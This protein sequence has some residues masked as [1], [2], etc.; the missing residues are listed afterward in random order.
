MHQNRWRPGLCPG[1]HWGSLQRSRT[2]YSAKHRGTSAWALRALA[3]NAWGRQVEPT[4]HHHLKK[5]TPPLHCSL[6]V[7]IDPPLSWPA[8]FSVYSCEKSYVRQS[9]LCVWPFCSHDRSNAVCYFLFF[10][11]H[12]C[13]FSILFW[14]PHSVISVSPCYALYS[15]QAAYLEN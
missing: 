7:V 12:Q 14:Y 3:P 2:P 11:L 5:H 8:S 1:P 4:A 15:S 13:L 9:E 6:E 10:K